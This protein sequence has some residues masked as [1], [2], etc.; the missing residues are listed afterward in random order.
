MTDKVLLI[1]IEIKK[2]VNIIKILSIIKRIS[3]IY[4][5]RLKH[6]FREF[7]AINFYGNKFVV[8]EGWV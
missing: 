3:T 8:S 1:L 2:T 7:S 6:F 5:R 4:S